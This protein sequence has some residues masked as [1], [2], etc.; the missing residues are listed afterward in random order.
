MYGPAGMSSLPAKKGNVLDTESFEFEGMRVGFYHGGQGRPLMLI[1][2]SGPGASSLGNWKAVLSP[3]AEHY[4]IFAMDL[5]GFGRSDRKPA[6]PYFDYELWVRQAAAMLKR[7]PGEL[8]GVIGHSLSGSIALTLASKTPRIV[9]VMTTGSMGASFEMIEGTR[10]TWKCPR[11]R[12]ELVKA[13][14]CLIHDTSDITEDYLQTREKVIYAE[15]YAD[16]FDQMF[17]GDQYR[18]IEA[19]ILSEAT[20]RGI[21]Q[22]VLMLHGRDDHSFPPS[23]S[24][25]VATQINSADMVLLSHCSHSVAVERAG[26]FLALANDFFDRNFNKKNA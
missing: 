3:L 9:G 4:E 18:Y 13:L 15:G 24:Q 23:I 26:T 6:P 17:E 19:T 8:V 20:L 22:P 12:Q 10:L 11:N 1:H 25:A 5:L 7:I 16:Y 14:S 2:G 21:R